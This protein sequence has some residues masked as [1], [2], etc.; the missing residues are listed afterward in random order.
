MNDI[1]DDSVSRF[2]LAPRE[3]RVDGLW[4]YS[5]FHTKNCQF[6]GIYARKIACLGKY[7][8]KIL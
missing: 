8:V 6:I 3:I 4:S 7:Y 2:Y 5:S 1:A